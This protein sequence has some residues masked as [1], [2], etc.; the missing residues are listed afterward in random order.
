V[1]GTFGDASQGAGLCDL[2]ADALAHEHLQ[3]YDGIPSQ[4]KAMHAY[5]I[6]RA[7]GHTAQRGWAKL[8]LDRRCF[9][10]GGP[11]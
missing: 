2:A 11:S 8:I 1:L 7:W 6:R 4:A 9:A 3:F 5:Q 10:G